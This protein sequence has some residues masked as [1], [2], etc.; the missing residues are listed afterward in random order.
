M[1]EKKSQTHGPSTSAVRRQ[2]IAEAVVQGKVLPQIAAE[3]G[4]T[5]QS[6]HYHLQQPETQGLIRQWMQ[7]HHDSIKRMIPRALATVNKG[8][9]PSNEMRDRLNAVKTLGTVMGWAEGNTDG[10]DAGRAGARCAGQL[11]EIL[12]YYR[13][14]T[15]QTPD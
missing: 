5:K 12:M 14:I 10:N 9:K 7:P 3:L 11:E 1:R 6:V 13:Q 2:K 15:T 8:L 4:I